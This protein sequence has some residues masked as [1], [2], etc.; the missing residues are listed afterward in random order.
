MA[1][2]GHAS[3]LK[4]WRIYKFRQLKKIHSAIYRQ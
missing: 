1:R 3:L 2:G 4:S